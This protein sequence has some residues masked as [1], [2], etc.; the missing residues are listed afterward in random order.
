MQYRRIAVLG[1]T[2]SLALAIILLMWRATAIVL[3]PGGMSALYQDM[4]T[5]ASFYL[6]LGG[7]LAA[8]FAPSGL[9]IGIW[10]VAERSR[11]G[12]LLHVLLV[13]AA[14]T[15][16]RGCE[17]LMLFAAREPDDDG[18]TG[19]A[20][21]PAY[22]ILLALFATYYLALLAKRLSREARAASRQQR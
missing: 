6:W 14:F 10:F 18:P 12:W 2:A 8:T 9:A 3:W 13:P 16:V 4:L 7:W 17:A 21:A 19:W 15:V 1:A 11:R 22:L 20:T 5:P